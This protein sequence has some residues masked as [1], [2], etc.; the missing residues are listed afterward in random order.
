MLLLWEQLLVWVPMGWAVP[1][2]PQPAQQGNALH[3]SLH[4]NL[5]FFS[6]LSKSKQSP[7]MCFYYSVFSHT[8]V[9]T[10]LFLHLP[11]RQ[12]P[13]GGMQAADAPGSAT[14]GC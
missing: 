6:I 8:E 12:R 10:F 7:E 4:H 2:S 1:T 9:T 13:W 5:G 11:I 14:Q 3:W